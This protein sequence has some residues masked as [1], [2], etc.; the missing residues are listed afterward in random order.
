MKTSIP[1][2]AGILVLSFFSTVPLLAQVS[3]VKDINTHP[4]QRDGITD[5]WEIFCSC[6]D[7]LFFPSIT[8]E[9]RELWRTDGTAEGT[10]L[11]KDI[12][13]GFRPGLVRDPLCNGNGVVYFIGID[14]ANGAE[15]WS[16]DGTVIGTK[17][18][19]DVVPGP[20]GSAQML[21]IFGNTVYFITDHNLDGELEIWKSDG[22]ANG[23]VLVTTL[24][25][26][27]RLYWFETKSSNT[28]LFLN[29]TNPA[30]NRVEAWSFNVA[31]GSVTKL[32]EKA[33]IIDAE[34]I[35]ANIV[36]SISDQ[37][38]YTYALFLSDGTPGGTTEFR[39]LD[40]SQ[41][42]MFHTF[43][44]KLIFNVSGS[45]WITDGTDAG[46]TVLTSGSV[47]ASAIV[48]ND[49]YGIG[50]DFATTSNRLFKFD[51]STVETIGLNGTLNDI[52]AY[53]EIAVLNNRLVL[54]YYD[55]AVGTE[56]GISDGMREN[57][58][59]LKDINPGP[60][61]SA[62]RAWATFK[63]R[64][65]FLAN[66]AAY[67]SQIWSTDGSEGG[68]SL[69]QIPTSNESAF[70]YPMQ[71]MKIHN[72]KLQFLATSGAGAYDFDVFTT[73]GTEAN[74]TKKIDFTDGAYLLGGTDKRLIYYSGRKLYITDEA[75]DHASSF[76]EFGDYGFGTSADA[77][78]TFGDKMIYTVFN[79][80][81]SVELG[82]EFWITDGT[83]SG[84]YILKDINPG[85]G[86]GVSGKASVVGSKL[87][88][89]GNDPTH[90]SELWI[91]D[92]TPDGTLLLKDISPGAS[93]SRPTSFCTFNDKVIFSA[94]TTDA[95]REVWIT[96]G[97]D[98]GT[99]QLS[100]IV[101]GPI[102][103]DPQD[104]ISLGNVV[105]FNAFDEVNGWALWK[106]DG[107]AAGTKMVKDIIP[108]NKKA[109][110]TPNKFTAVGNKLYFVVNDGEHGNEPW[111]SDG[112]PEGTYVLDVMPGT[113]GSA[114]SM[115]TAL[116]NGVVYFSANLELWRTKGTAAT[117]VRVSELE[118]MEMIALDNTLFFTA[119][120]TDYG[121]ELFK[122]EFTKFDQQVSITPITEKT[123][124]DAPFQIEASASS[125]L[126]IAI[127][128]EEELA[129]ENTIATIT[130]A[131]TVKVTVQQ[132]GDD[133]FN[134]AQA[135]QTFCV[136]PAKPSIAI[137]GEEVGQPV[138]T[139]NSN[140][141]NQ[142]F[143]QE[144]A[145][146]NEKSQTFIP[147][148]NGT[149]KLKVTIDGCTSVFSDKADVII[150]GVETFGDAITFFPNPVK[151]TLKI[152]TT[153]DVEILSVTITDVNGR[154][155]RTYDVGGSEAVSY[156]LAGYPAGVYIVRI[157]T[158]WGVSYNKI[159]KE[160]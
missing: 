50:F 104:F 128:V 105:L 34:N 51:G 40:H 2:I 75:L 92:G 45:T 116:K 1:K 41:P 29:V 33:S 101:E 54:Q 91:T 124:G 53:R 90:G 110:I 88:F 135:S 19:K 57:I 130:K 64:V 72:N 31:S 85:S 115:F 118:P 114:P 18:V 144:E 113:D 98:L 151:E 78:Y 119:P 39:D 145:I 49:F 48:E 96:D 37:T 146:S 157:V 152:E 14:A 38:D 122:A 17:L 138:L 160:F 35:G 70:P 123:L 117:T 3:L 95:G 68:T 63:N 6:G 94:T 100:D 121:T 25:S 127:T 83:E 97:T 120:H 52:T 60:E 10:I 32:F 55:A 80:H 7:N 20:N 112:T 9:G 147:A 133:F 56:L 8:A 150:M 16:S 42:E 43:N 36:L 106:T 81:G 74:T 158:E 84:T 27:D 109:I 61:R 126:P 89:D 111:I 131:G 141:G 134:P 66:D 129:I 108:G 99:Y 143:E 58:T 73:D 69:L 139:S 24:S 44:D 107:T 76:Y 156:S 65:Y 5:V 93:A 155:M 23:T 30:Q 13:K 4:R 149:Y 137:T 15:L 62:P 102:G 154:A 67:G 132:A 59:L 71:G 82:T 22:S 77:N 87:I 103:S 159:F 153:G 148:E 21:G 46:T 26:P 125:G 12:N 136:L 47:N 28:H 79:I 86:D 140:T 142:W 11:I